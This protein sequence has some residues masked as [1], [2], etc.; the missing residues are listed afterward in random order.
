MPTLDFHLD[1]RSPFERIHRISKG[2]TLPTIRVRLLDGS[3]AVDFTSGTLTFR[4]DAEDG[5]NK[6]PDK[7]AVLVGPATDGTIEYTFAAADVDTEGRFFAQFK[8]VISG[9]SHLI[10]N[11]KSQRLRV[12]IGPVI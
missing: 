9:V 1:D 4:M 7:S 10:P 8:V 11:N 3:T 5:T 2:A 6:V 12:E